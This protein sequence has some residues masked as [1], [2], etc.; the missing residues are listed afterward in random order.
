MIEG[1]QIRI[2][3]A[4]ST[5]SEVIKQMESLLAARYTHR[6]SRRAFLGQ[7]GKLR[8]R[9]FLT[10]DYQELRVRIAQRCRGKCEVEGCDSSFEHVHH[11][12]PVAFKPALALR[13]SNCLGVCRRCH[14][15]IENA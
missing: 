1:I 15:E 5:A 8:K 10:R 14:E 2:P 6:V 11:K 12:V 3:A 4:R 13:D 9:L 7:W